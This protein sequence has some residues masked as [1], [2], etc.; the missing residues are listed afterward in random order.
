MKNNMEAPQKAK[1]DPA[2]PLL[3]ECELGCLHLMILL[4]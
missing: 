2:I 4:S 1:N 3:K